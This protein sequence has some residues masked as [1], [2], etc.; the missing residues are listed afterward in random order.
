MACG[1]GLKKMCYI[2][3]HRQPRIPV[4]TCADV[5]EYPYYRGYTSTLPKTG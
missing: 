3:E 5:A 1:V 2:G 4:F